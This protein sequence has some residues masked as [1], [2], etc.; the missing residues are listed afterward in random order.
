MHNKWHIIDSLHNPDLTGIL[1][2]HETPY[3][4]K[5][6]CF[7]LRS[8]HADARRM[9]FFMVEQVFLLMGEVWSMH[10]IDIQWP[11]GGERRPKG[12][13]E[14]IYVEIFSCLAIKHEFYFTTPPSNTWHSS[15]LFQPL[16]QLCNTLSLKTI[17]GWPSSAIIIG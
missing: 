6:E 10:N 2:G 14:C 13:E 3:K 16:I 1:M 11:V 5:K 12:R 8:C 7:L 9:L 15:P 17:A 4:I